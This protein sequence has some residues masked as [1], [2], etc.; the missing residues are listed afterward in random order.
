MQPGGGGRMGSEAGLGV[1]GSTREILGPG[2]EL[3][4]SKWIKLN[5]FPVVV[6]H[7][8]VVE[9]ISQSY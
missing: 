9:I 4:R 1:N 6:H 8:P 7:M 2:A 3:D 5:H